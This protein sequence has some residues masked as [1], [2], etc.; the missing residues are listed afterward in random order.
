MTIYTVKHWA[1][2]VFIVGAVMMALIT[3]FGRGKW[4]TFVH[5]KL[6][7]SSA[8]VVFFGA[9]YNRKPRY[10]IVYPRSQR[11]PVIA[12]PYH[13]GA[14]HVRG[15]ELN[16]VG[17]FLDGKLV[18]KWE[19]GKGGVVVIPEQN[20]SSSGAIVCRD[21]PA[22][23]TAEISGLDEQQWMEVRAYVLAHPSIVSP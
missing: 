11:T 16:R 12:L 20:G 18:D 3:A 23:A 14:P 15:V 22:I 21:F 19:W 5:Q 9:P 6:G 1:L 8:T 10:L 17:I 13:T 7:S 4:P 2:G